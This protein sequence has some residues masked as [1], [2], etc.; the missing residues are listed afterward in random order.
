[1]RFRRQEP[2]LSGRYGR[3]PNTAT[4]DG[5]PTNTLPLAIIGVMNLLS[6]KVSRLFAA[7]VLS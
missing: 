3:I 7:W 1:M 5:V 6:E 4:L 2:R